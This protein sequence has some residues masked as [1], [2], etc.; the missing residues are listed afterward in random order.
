MNKRILNKLEKV[1]LNPRRPV[2]TLEQQIEVFDTARL[3]LRLAAPRDIFDATANEQLR[4]QQ[5]QRI[6]DF[7]DLLHEHLVTEFGT[8]IIAVY[9]CAPVS[10]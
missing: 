3:V 8:V 4:K 7:A 2:L 9:P 10:T 6:K 5:T 1:T